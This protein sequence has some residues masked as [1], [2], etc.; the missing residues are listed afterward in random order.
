MEIERKFLIDAVPDDVRR[1]DGVAIDQGYLAI[2]ED[3]SEVRLRRAGARR[4]LTA[5]SG[6]GLVRAESEIELSDQQFGALWP[7]TEGRRIAKT[8]VR[9][10]AGGGLTIELDIYRGVLSGLIVAEVEFSS[11]DAAG[12]FLA[13]PWF[14]REVTE[15]ARYKNRRLAVDGRP[16]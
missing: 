9:I 15:D 3:G 13:P 16:T 7:A 4:T 2:G 5:K 1:A 14:G 10:P 8:R 12:D 11:V 6:A